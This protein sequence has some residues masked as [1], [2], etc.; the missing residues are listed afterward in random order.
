MTDERA[1]LI[2][3]AITLLTAIA[4]VWYAAR[5]LTDSVRVSR[6]QFFATV[7]GLLSD[8]DDVHAKLRP[9]GTWASDMLEGAQNVE[10]RA[11]IELYMGLFEYC[12]R[13]MAQG[14]LSRT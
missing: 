13:L 7:R 4:G 2:L 5:T 9:G 14:L 8:Y 1:T 3:T 11:R 10:H 6:A 12:E